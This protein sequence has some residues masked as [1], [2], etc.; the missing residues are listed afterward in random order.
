MAAP[1]CFFL[2][3][4]CSLVVCAAASSVTSFSAG[5]A[6][7][8][9]NPPRDGEPFWKMHIEFVCNDP[10]GVGTNAATVQLPVGLM[11]GTG[12]LSVREPVTDAVPTET[13]TS[14]TTASATITSSTAVST[15]VTTA[16]VTSSTDTTQT[17]TATTET[18]T[19]TTET[20]TS[21]LGRRLSSVA[22]DDEQESARIRELGVRC[23]VVS[24]T[25]S[26]NTLSLSLRDYGHPPHGT[27]TSGTKVEQ[28]VY[29]S[30]A[31]TFSSVAQGAL[32]F[33]ISTDADTTTVL[34]STNV[35]PRFVVGP[36]TTQWVSYSG[37]TIPT[38]P[39]AFSDPITFVGDKKIKFWLPAYTLM[40]LLETPDLTL[41]ASVFPGPSQDLQ[42]FERFRVTG[43]D[44][45]EVVDI[46]V[47]RHQTLENRS[48]SRPG[49]FSQLRIKFPA[50]SEPL[51]SREPQL[52]SASVSGRIKVGVG[53][54]HR[55]FF[56]AVVHTSPFIEF[57]VVES[58]SISFAV[59]ACHAGNEFPDD[60]R[61]QAEYTHLDFVILESTGEEQFRGILPQLW[62]T[63]PRSDE[64][65][66]MTTPPSERSFSRDFC[67]SMLHKTG[68][69]FQAR[70]KAF[71]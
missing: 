21:T 10:L 3:T 29:P 49:K 14:S 8:E 40:P 41:W 66:A 47:L 56:H 52:F 68:E 57:V 63:T 12:D 39:G 2:L 31:V 34:A 23:E 22:D 71:L 16:T 9:G 4:A 11:Q 42:W 59:Y 65:V 5:L 51:Q 37:G 33:A 62:G 54:K 64:V 24:A 61:L 53:T 38:Y 36:D 58:P 18:A 17:V 45:Q 60:Q 46:S 20:A 1:Q 50:L 7:Y 43:I 6:T 48:S 35:L 67:Q 25:L 32:S 69:L 27:C 28:F 19:A 15:T 44:G 55:R 13:A 26:G 70:C 30:S